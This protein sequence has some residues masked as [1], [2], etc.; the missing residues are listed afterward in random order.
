[1][2]T[3]Y[4]AKTGQIFD[5]S[6]NDGGTPFS[7]TLGAGQVVPGFDAGIVGMRVGETRV[8]EIPPSQGYGAIPNGGIPANSTLIFVVTLESI[9]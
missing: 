3:G 4:L 9:S 6:V 1:M 8:I 7:V 2:Y 5:D